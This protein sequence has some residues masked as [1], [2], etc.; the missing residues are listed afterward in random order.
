VHAHVAALAKVRGNEVVDLRAHVRRRP[1]QQLRR[2]GL[3]LG[4]GLGLG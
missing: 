3:G 4:L 1:Q 2:K